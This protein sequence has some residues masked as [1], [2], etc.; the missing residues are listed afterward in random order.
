MRGSKLINAKEY[1]RS[2]ESGF[3]VGGD[4]AKA[5]SLSTKTS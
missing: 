4:T 1:W 2:S 5:R 3:V